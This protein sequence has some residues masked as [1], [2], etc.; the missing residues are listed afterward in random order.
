MKT[1]EVAKA[2]GI[3]LNWMVAKCEGKVVNQRHRA[4][5]GLIKGMWG[6]IRYKP[7]TDWSQGGPIIGRERISLDQ[8]KGHP[9]RAYLGTPVRY[10]HAMFAPEGEPLIAAMRCYVASKLGERVEVPEDLE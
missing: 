10:E 4:Y 7:S 6:A 1:I 3:T 2:T 8:F 9:C 5:Q